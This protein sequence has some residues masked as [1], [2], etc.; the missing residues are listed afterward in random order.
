MLPFLINSLALSVK[1]KRILSRVHSFPCHWE[2]TA[3]PMWIFSFLSQ[4]KSCFFTAPTK[5][6]LGLSPLCCPSLLLWAL[7]WKHRQ[8][9]H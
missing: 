1:G 3:S 8:K 6:I 5:S 4:T 9:L 7:T 2:A